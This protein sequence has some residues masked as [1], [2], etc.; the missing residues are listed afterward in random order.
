MIAIAFAKDLSVFESAVQPDVI[1]PLLCLGILGSLACILILN[2]FQK[3][4]NPTHAAI[5]YSFEPVWATL[6]GWQ[7][8]L[9]EPSIWL[10]TGFLL[11]AGNI[12]VELDESVA[13]RYLSDDAGPE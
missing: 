8:G 13:D 2:I 3:Y 11:L 7:V 9:V 12:I 6:Y 10:L 4:L 5:I 1:I